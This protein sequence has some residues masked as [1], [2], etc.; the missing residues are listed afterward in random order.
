ML[1][2]VA[3]PDRDQHGEELSGFQGRRAPTTTDFDSEEAETFEDG[4]QLRHQHARASDDDAQIGDTVNVAMEALPEELKT[5]SCCGEIE[6]LSYDEIATI[7]D[8][9]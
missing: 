2:Y 6:G 7:M 3:L 8:C 5:R 1:L 4:D 9:R